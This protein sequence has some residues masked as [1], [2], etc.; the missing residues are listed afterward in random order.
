MTASTA[1]WLDIHG[2][3]YLPLHSQDEEEALIEMLNKSDFRV[4]QAPSFNAE[5]TIAYNDSAG[6]ALQM[7]SYLPTDLAKLRK[8]NDYAASI[9]AKHPTRFGQLAALPTDK[10]DACVEEIKRTTT[11]DI[12]KIAPD[13]FAMTTVY[14]GVECVPT[15]ER[16]CVLNAG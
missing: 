12:F 10:P 8:A 16:Y 14:N 13:G 3:F 7:L 5:Q 9:V 1:S 11:S 6:V 4:S 2:H 15:H